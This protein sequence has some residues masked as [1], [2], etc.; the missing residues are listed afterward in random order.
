MELNV[1]KLSDWHTAANFKSAITKYFHTGL[2]EDMEAYSKI[3]IFLILAFLSQYSQRMLEKRLNWIR[4]SLVDEA[5]GEVPGG[6]VV[7]EGVSVVRDIRT[8][9]EVLVVLR[10]EA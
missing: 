3:L 4:H 5:A 7:T 2:N 6:V 9:T 1:A 8:A 10:L